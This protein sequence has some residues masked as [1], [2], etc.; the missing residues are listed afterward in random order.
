MGAIK[1]H[2]TISLY[3]DE[4]HA[5]WLDSLV[6]AVNAGLPDGQDITREQYLFG[7][8]SDWIE[9]EYKAEGSMMPDDLTELDACQRERN[10]LLYQRME[11]QEYIL[12]EI[13]YYR[14]Q[15]QTHRTKGEEQVALL[16]K[17]I[18]EAIEALW[19]RFYQVR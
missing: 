12:G 17:G 11:M 6:R 19:K 4:Q 3:L 5:A 14:E 15:E 7:M 2:L 1:E 10:T 9:E 13:T 16:Y 18:E 8:I